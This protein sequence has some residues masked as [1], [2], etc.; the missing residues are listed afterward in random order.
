M[1][2]VFHHKSL[3]SLIRMPHRTAAARHRGIV[4]RSPGNPTVSLGSQLWAS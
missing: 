1:T 4:R 2:A 3:V